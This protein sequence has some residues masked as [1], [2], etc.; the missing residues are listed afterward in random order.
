MAKFK[1]YEPT[2]EQLNKR[3]NSASGDFDKFIKPEFELFTPEKGENWIRILPATWE[4]ADHWALSI[5]VHYGLG[6]DKGSALCPQKM[7][8]GTCPV[9]EYRA[10]M[11]SKLDEE[12]LKELR[13]SQRFLAWVIDRNN[14][15]EGPKLWAM[16]VTKVDQV[17]AKLAFDRNTRELLP[18]TSPDHGYDIY[19]DRQ[20]EKLRT[21][22]AGF[23]LAS[24]ASSVDDKWMEF[25][26]TTPVPDTLLWRDYDEMSALFEGTTPRNTE[27][28]RRSRGREDARPARG[29]REDADEPRSRGMGRNDDERRPERN[30]DREDDT[31]PIRSRGDDELRGPTRNEELEGPQRGRGRDDEPRRVR[32]PDD[33]PRRGRD[34]LDD[35][36]R[37][38]ST[39]PRSRVDE[40]KERFGGR[41]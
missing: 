4:G 8:H 40:L 28:P 39:S 11:A 21:Q 34:S 2:A 23:T 5:Y 16:S 3:A 31:P 7:K 29:N 36:P 22:Y 25:V 6:P 41:K 10:R 33:A 35:D 9:C 17:I 14:E 26:E 15:K 24:R 27:E 19:F 30:Q 20:G 1:Y 32:E 37:G 13:P 12:E 18:I 38:S